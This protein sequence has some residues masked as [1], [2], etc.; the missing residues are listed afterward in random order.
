[1]R[2]VLLIS[3]IALFF[4]VWS[5]DLQVPLFHHNKN[6]LWFWFHPNAAIW[7]SSCSIYTHIYQ[8][9]FFCYPDVLLNM[10]PDLTRYSRWSPTR[11]NSTPANISV[12]PISSKTRFGLLNYW[13]DIWYYVWNDIF[14]YCK[15]FPPGGSG[16]QTSTKIGKRQNK[17]RNNIKIQNT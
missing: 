13:Y 4:S 1:M 11:V 14:I 10:H 7:I 2:H 16:Q 5:N 17:R 9:R 3:V 15:W 8:S 12:F 6:W